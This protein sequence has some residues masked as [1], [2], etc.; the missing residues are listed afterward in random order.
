[1][2]SGQGQ[3][4]GRILVYS[5]LIIASYLV[6]LAEFKL[7]ANPEDYFAEFGAAE[8]WQFALLFAACGL[9]AFAVSRYRQDRQL[10]IMVLA[11]LLCMAVREADAFFD[12][13]VF[14]GAWQVVVTVILLTAGFIL[15]RDFGAIGRQLKGISDSSP[16][17][18]AVAAFLSLA[19]FSRLF[20]RKE[21][22]MSL[23]GDE[24][25]R[26]VKNAAEEGTETL[27]Y[28]LLLVGVVDHLWRYRRFAKSMQND[29]EES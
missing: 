12:R 10:N 23:M 14:D 21:F 6:L 27:G 26:I 3:I 4:L 28:T 29:T 22:W 9:L 2:A 16:F 18:I 8:L 19:L 5:G 13:F 15:R 7:T 17:G 1:M 25:I 24:Y 11:L 20:G